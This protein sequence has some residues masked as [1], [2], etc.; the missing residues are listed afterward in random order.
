MDSCC[1]EQA[2]SN[3]VSDAGKQGFCHV[4]VSKKACQIKVG[5]PTLVLGLQI[6]RSQMI[7]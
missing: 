5:M 1:P 4:E 2:F 3:A 7:E 6:G